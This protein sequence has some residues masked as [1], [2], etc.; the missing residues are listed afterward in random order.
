MDPSKLIVQGING[1]GIG[2]LLFLLA[3]GLSL[4]FGLMRIVNIAHGSYFLIGGYVGFTLF[5][6]TGNFLLAAIAGMAVGAALGFLSERLFLRSLYGAHGHDAILLTFALSIIFAD[7][8]LM[9]WGTPQTIPAPGPLAVTIDI[10]GSPYPVYRLFIVLLGALVF[11]GLWWFQERT[12]WGAIVR[13]GVDDREMVTGLGI[14]IPRVFTLV[15][16]FGALLAGFGGVMGA[17]ILGLYVGMDFEISMLAI[18]VIIVGGIGSLP[19]LL[20]TCIF[21]GL[22]DTFGKILWPRFA[23]FTIYAILAMV[24]LW[25]PTGLF[26]RRE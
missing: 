7:L 9:A 25:K 19:G 24:L 8:T 17:P 10:L 4:M 2:A 11:L 16:T 26:G 1:I 12:Q 5:H 22:A 14:N 3:S 20:A 21:I 23:V 15:F 18:A 13:A 6:L